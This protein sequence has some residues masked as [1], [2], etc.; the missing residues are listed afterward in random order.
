MDYAKKTGALGA[1]LLLVGGC[2]ASA[3][4]GATLPEG[5]TDLS[6]GALIYA[7]TA[8]L[9]KDDS[10]EERPGFGGSVAAMTKYGTAVAKSKGVGAN[11]ALALIKIEAYRMTGDAPGGTTLSSDTIVRRAKACMGS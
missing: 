7:A 9:D 2:N 6:C 11:E 5:E 8:L 10:G 1:I 3:G 4:G